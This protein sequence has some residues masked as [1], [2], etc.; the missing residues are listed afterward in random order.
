MLAGGALKLR[1]V[2]VRVY[3]YVYTCTCIRVRVYVTSGE[4]APRGHNEHVAEGHWY[5]VEL[6]PKISKRISRATSNSEPI[7]MV[8]PKWTRVGR[9]RNGFS[10]NIHFLTRYAVISDLLKDLFKE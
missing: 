10:L 6:R 1:S 4:V 7:A 5:M 8:V 2:R 3:V 9:S